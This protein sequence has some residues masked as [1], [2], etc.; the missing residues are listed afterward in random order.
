MQTR[1]MF[2]WGQLCSR[3][4]AVEFNVRSKS[5]YFSLSS[6]PQ[7]LPRGLQELFGD[8]GKV[9]SVLVH[10]ENRIKKAQMLANI[11]HKLSI[12]LSRDCDVFEASSFLPDAKNSVVK[13]VFIRD[14]SATCVSEDTLRTL[15]QENDAICVFS[16]KSE[17]QHCWQELWT[18]A[19]HEEVS[20][21]DRKCLYV[22]HSPEAEHHPTTLDIKNSDV[23]YSVNEAIN[24][25]RECVDII[26]ESKEVLKLV[27]KQLE[28]RRS[29]GFPV[30]VIEGLDATGASSR[31]G[32][33]P[34]VSHSPESSASP[35]FSAFPWLG[36]SPLK[37]SAP[38]QSSASPPNL[39]P[40]QNPLKSKTTLTEALKESM[41]ATLL[42][43]PPQRLAPFRQRFDSEPPLIRRA[44]YA[45]GNYITAAHIAKESLRAPVIVDRYWHST[46]AYAIATAVGGRM[47]NLPKPG[48]ELYQWPEDLLQPNLVLLLTLSPEERVR[49]L[50]D[51]GQ[52]KTTEETEL[53]LN[54]IFRLKVEEAYKRIQNPRCMIV[55]ASPSPQ[56]VLQQV[57]RLI[58]NKCHL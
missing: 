2:R 27:D 32:T 35:E 12:T 42:K 48:S 22:N 40:Y 6:N 44:F 21:L 16:Y 51:R 28:T 23:F 34:E 43:S 11:K 24:V 3:V 56:Q 9:F 41:N 19:N 20:K 52:D 33:F 15:Q 29:D 37:C 17:G 14:K 10:S 58:R 8:S 31:F 4:F 5:L 49:R 53:E 38:P 26:P 13:G 55:D 7:V 50:R 30:I 57:Q 36:C 47:E 1:A 25:L 39:V 46:A 45:L 18:P 54:Q